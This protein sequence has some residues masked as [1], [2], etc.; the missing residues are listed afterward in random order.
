MAFLS[1]SEIDCE[2]YFLT[3]MILNFGDDTYEPIVRGEAE[4]QRLAG[5]NHAAH[6]NIWKSN[7]H[8]FEVSE[9]EGS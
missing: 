6:V 7:L 9:T 3:I 8:F 2:N 4:N 1:M 5:R